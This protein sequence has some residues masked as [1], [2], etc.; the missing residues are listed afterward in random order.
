MDYRP[1][2]LWC[3]C[4]SPATLVHQRADHKGPKEASEW[5]HRHRERPEQHLEATLHWDALP[6]KVGLIV[7]LLHELEKIQKQT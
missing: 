7:K 5:E 3:L 1:S 4:H 2:I 6:I